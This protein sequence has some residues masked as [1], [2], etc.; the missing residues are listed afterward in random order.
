[1][2]KIIFDEYQFQLDDSSYLIYHFLEIFF[3]LKNVFYHYWTFQNPI[4]KIY[5]YSPIPV[6]SDDSYNAKALWMNSYCSGV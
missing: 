4:C 5:D 2:F 6:G 1:M 3:H